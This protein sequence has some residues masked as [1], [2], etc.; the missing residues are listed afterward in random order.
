MNPWKD[1]RTD[2]ADQ[3]GR[4]QVAEVEIK[5][6]QS[7]FELEKIDYL[8]TIRRQE[9]DFMLFQQLLEQVQPLIRRDCN[10]SNLEKIRRES[11]W[12]EDNGFWKIPQPIIMKTSLPP[13]PCLGWEVSSPGSKPDPGLSAQP[14][15]PLA[16]IPGSSDLSFCF[17]IA[18]STGLQ[19]RSAR[20]TSTVDNGEPGMQ[21]E[22]RYRLLLSRSDSENIASNYFRPK[23]ASQILSADPMKSL[24]HHSSPPGLSSPLG[25][26][27]AIPPTQAPE[28]PQ[29]RP[30]RLE[31]LDIPFTKAKRKKSKSSSGGEPL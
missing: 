1:D 16:L 4:L 14:P 29:P 5:D 24:A 26:S 21:E 23:R 20:K 8:A 6:L 28:M 11:C 31:S 2:G 27:S 19:N 12:D 15:I 17:L 30:F 18:V 10:Y 25:N 22:D 9:R 3:N 13:S 7:E